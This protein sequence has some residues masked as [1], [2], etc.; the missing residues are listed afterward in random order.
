MVLHT[1]SDGLR[2]LAW[3]CTGPRASLLRYS[4]GLIPAT[5]HAGDEAAGATAVWGAG[6]LKCADD[7][8]MDAAGD[9]RCMVLSTREGV[10]IVVAHSVPSAQRMTQARDEAECT[11][12]IYFNISCLFNAL[13]MMSSKLDEITPFFAR[14]LPG[15]A[16]L[17]HFLLAPLA[18]SFCYRSTSL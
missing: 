12:E 17:Y 6:A 18:A 16:I 7:G 5:D 1:S 3:L 4:V 11:L 14:L 2:N 9:C 13:S 15:S 8:A 10:P